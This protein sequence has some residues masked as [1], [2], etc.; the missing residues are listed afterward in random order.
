MLCSTKMLQYVLY[1]CMYV[2]IIS[3]LMETGTQRI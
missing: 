3:P 1:V 2:D